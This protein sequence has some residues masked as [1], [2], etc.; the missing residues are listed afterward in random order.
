MSDT[1][2]VPESQLENQPGTAPQEGTQQAQTIIVEGR[3]IPKDLTKI[4]DPD[5]REH[6]QALI[7]ADNE[8]KKTAGQGDGQPPAGQDQQQQQQPPTQQ[9]QGAAP[10]QDA[11]KP[12]GPQQMVPVAALMSERER[13][14]I[15]EANANYY[16]GIAEATQRGTQ[17]PAAQGQQ[18]PPQQTPQQKLDAINGQIDALAEKF[19]NGDITMKEFKAQERALTDQAQTIRE[20][21]ILAKVPKSQPQA[22]PAEDLLLEERTAELETKHPYVLH[23]FPEYM[24]ADPAQR[25]VLEARQETLRVEARAALRSQGVQA[26]PRADLLFRQKIAELAD[27]YGPMWFPNVQVQRPTGQ[28]TQ[29]GAQPGQK[30]LTTKQQ[31]RL[32]AIVTAGQQ[33]PDITRVGQQG[34]QSEITE[35]DI[36]NMS[37]DKIANLPSHVKEKFGI[38]T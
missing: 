8:A 32:D 4:E 19:D 27:Q 28:Q 33:P 23:V 11:G 26:G 2:T 1:T 13:R 24:P 9:D 18:Q 21:M 34:T 37:E 31:S 29:P 16:K 10:T 7:D 38:P 6:Y 17:P 12:K 35:A 15:A 22:A 20:E 36:M 5:L 14:E 3:E 25:E 30:P